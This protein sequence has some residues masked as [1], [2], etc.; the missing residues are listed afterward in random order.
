MKRLPKSIRK[1]IYLT[2]ITAREGY[3]AGDER[4]FICCYLKF[5]YRHYTDED[6]DNEWYPDDEEIMDLFPEFALL[7]PKDISTGVWFIGDYEPI[8]T[9]IDYRKEVIRVNKERFTAMAFCAAMI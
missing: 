3:D 9:R 1:E 7:R 6:P 8:M 5:M 2:F 4:F